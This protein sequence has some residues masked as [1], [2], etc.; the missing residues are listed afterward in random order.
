MPGCFKA[1]SL[2]VRET[3]LT[4]EPHPVVKGPHAHPATRRVVLEGSDV[5]A[6]MGEAIVVAVGRQTRL[7]TIAASMNCT[8]VQESPLGTRLG[9]VLDV[10]GPVAVIGG[11]VITGAGLFYGLGTL[12]EMVTL[13]V[14]SGTQRHSLRTALAG[15]RRPG[16]RFAAAGPA[17]CSGAAP[18]RH[19][20]SGTSRH[21]LCRQNRHPDRRQTDSC[22]ACDRSRRNV[23]AWA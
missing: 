16:C 6:G 15:R 7:G 22:P 13:G 23:L 18:G 3:H 2:E 5:I 11:V 4:G 10:A 8:P 9:K 20:G 14:V 19:R 12:A 17:K 21:R 1:E